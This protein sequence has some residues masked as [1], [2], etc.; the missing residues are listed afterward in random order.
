MATSGTG[1]TLG[2]TFGTKD[3]THTLSGS[4]ANED[5]HTHGAGSLATPA[6]D[7]SSVTGQFNMHFSA[8][9][10]D[11]NGDGTTKEAVTGVGTAS[12][13]TTIPASI[14]HSHSVAQ[15]AAATIT[16]TSGAGSAHLH[17]A[18]TLATGTANPPSFVGNWMIKT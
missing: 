14:G 4:T 2:G 10:V 12:G 17:G 13:P 9:L 8:T 1:S 5:A 18:G 7:H 3:H 15:Q 16:G 6:H 11:I